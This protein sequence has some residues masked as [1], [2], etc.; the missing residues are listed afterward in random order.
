MDVCM[1]QCYECNGNFCE[2]D[3]E[4]YEGR[5][6]CSRCRDYYAIHDALNGVILRVVQIE[7]KE[8][9]TAMRILDEVLV[10]NSHLDHTGWLDRSVRAHKA[11]ILAQ[12]GQHEEAIVALKMLTSDYVAHRSTYVG[13]ED[14]ILNQTILALH[15]RDL[16]KHDEALAALRVAIEDPTVMGMQKALKLYVEIAHVVGAPV[17]SSYAKRAV[18]VAKLWGIDVS[19]LAIDDAA[20]MI[21]HVTTEHDSANRRYDRLSRE[22]RSVKN[23]AE[24]AQML[25]EYAASETVGWYREAA[26]RRLAREQGS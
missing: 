11:G 2:S 15:L 13:N 9:Q 8:P 14:L 10:A 5:P 22:L 7:R 26:C 21:R 16:G 4:D 17:P 20:N 6:V 24:R 18:D 19:S 25:S 1:I 3:V 23:K 12:Q